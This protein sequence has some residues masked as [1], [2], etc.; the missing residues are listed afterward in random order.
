VVGLEEDGTF[1]LNGLA[2]AEYEIAVLS[3]TTAFD[4]QMQ[5]YQVTVNAGT[6]ASIDIELGSIGAILDIEVVATDG[7][8]LQSSQVLLYRGIINFES[9]GD[10]REQ[11]PALLAKGNLRMGWVP[12]NPLRI[13]GV[14]PGV[15]SVCVVPIAGDI[16]DPEAAKRA[17]AN[18]EQ[19][20][21]HCSKLTMKADPPIRR[22]VVK[23]PPPAPLPPAPE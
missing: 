22:H 3:M 20:K 4:S 17:H 8:D 12:P 13:V 15:Y 5:S 7:S 21:V 1:A 16:R 2:A 23:V 18:I 14:A 19:V 9:V 10:A 6:S 11:L